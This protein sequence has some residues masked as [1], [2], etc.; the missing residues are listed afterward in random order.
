MTS[1]KAMDQLVATTDAQREFLTL[2]KEIGKVSAALSKSLEFF[3]GVCKERGGVF[4]AEFNQTT[5]ATH[6]LSSSGIAMHFD[7]FKR[8]DGKPAAKR[9]QFQNLA[10]AFKVLFRARREGWLMAEA[11][12]SQ[13]EFRVAAFLG[14]DKQAMA[15]I[16]NPDYDVHM[17][18]ASELN[19]VPL[20]EVTTG[21]TE[22][23]RQ[24]AKSETFKPLY[25]GTKGTPDQER[26]YRAFRQR[27]PELAATQEAW[28]YEVLNTKRLVTPWGMQYYW[29]QASMSRSGYV[30]VTSSV[31]NYPVQA[32][33]TAEIIP[34]ALVYFWHR[35][36][37]RN[38]M[39]RIVVVNTV[40]DSL[41]A[42]IAPD[43]REEFTQLAKQCFTTD[44]YNYL[45]KVYKLCFNVPLGCGIKIGPRWGKG[46]EVKFN[47]WNTGKEVR[48][49]E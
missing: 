40:H 45:D 49:N 12:G 38:L 35:L 10:R 17:F 28:V 44:V 20:S 46:D 42:E 25:G 37:E 26:Y 8:K 19:K 3:M 39:D 31:Y 16:E 41:A 23:M 36:R 1:Q 48:I 27:Y 47:V 5:T 30:N 24:K 34:V 29:P 2:R 32:L 14:Q 15:D 43:A 22:S 6:R 21:G 4:H 18:T 7:L 9:A 11:D 33:A 13:L